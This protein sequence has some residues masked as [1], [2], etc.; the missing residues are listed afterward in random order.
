MSLPSG[1][2]KKMVSSSSPFRKAA[3]MLTGSFHVKWVD[4]RAKH[5]C[6]L[7]H[8]G[9]MDVPEVKPFDLCIAF[10]YPAGFVCSNLAN[11]TIYLPGIYT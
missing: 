11:E 2:S 3:L 10:G 5:T 1:G 4:K 6:S 8:N 7:R 9:S